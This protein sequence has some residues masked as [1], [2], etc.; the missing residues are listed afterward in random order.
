MGMMLVQKENNRKIENM[1]FWKMP[2]LIITVLVVFIQYG[3]ARP[4]PAS[5]GYFISGLENLAGFHPGADGYKS[6]TIRI[7]YA[8]NNHKKFEINLDDNLNCN[9]KNENE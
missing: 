8:P 9:N 1:I 2:L 4:D 5:I 7:G 6:G 3:G